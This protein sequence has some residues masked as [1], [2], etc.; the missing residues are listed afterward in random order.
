[1]PTTVSLHPLPG[2]TAA[3][4]SLL[5]GYYGLEE[6]SVR[7][8]VRIS[9]QP[10]FRS[11][12]RPLR[13]KS[14][15]V[16]LSGKAICMFADMR[17]AIDLTK[18][19]H[20]LLHQ[21]VS[22]LAE[23]ESVP[24]GTVIE[25]PFDIP[26]PPDPDPNTLPPPP[27]GTNASPHL[28][29]PSMCFFG[30]NINSYQGRV[31]YEVVAT[32]TEVAS[33]ALGFI[34]LSPTVHSATTSLNPF[35][36]YDPRLLPTLL[37]P[38]IR[39]WRS[40]PGA[41]PVEYDIEVGAMAMGP[42]DTLRFAYRIVVASDS[43]RKGVRVKK[44]SL[45]LREHHVVG[46]QT[47][48]GRAENSEDPIERS[49]A[50]VKGMVELLRWEQAEESP[51]TSNST[52]ELSTMRSPDRR[53]HMGLS[54]GGK[55]PLPRPGFI[56]R[57]GDGLYAES[58]T[59]LKIPDV[60]S[61]AP[62][63]AKIT[64][65]P[66]VPPDGESL[67]AHVEVRHSLQVTIEF[68]GADKLVM[69]S[70]CV[71]SSVGREDCGKLLDHD[72]EIAP[73]L[74]Y[75]KIVGGADVWVPEYTEEDEL[76]E[77]VKSLSEE[78]LE[79]IRAVLAAEAEPA[80]SRAPPISAKANIPDDRAAEAPTAPSDD[81]NSIS[82]SDIVASSSETEASP[83]VSDSNHTFTD[84]E[85]EPIEITFDPEPNCGERDPLGPTRPA[86]LTSELREASVPLFARE[87]ASPEERASPTSA[88]S[89][90]IPSPASSLSS[91]YHS[92]LSHVSAPS[93]DT[94]LSSHTAVSDA[95]SSPALSAMPS[96]PGVADDL[97]LLK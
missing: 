56:C 41:I 72:P 10:G 44:I 71:L 4:Q 11:G 28:L 58:E 48:H 57:G 51:E 34:P 18:R 70:G 62:T 19:E 1:M 32:L 14:L 47:C 8:V 89:S 29:P 92:Y 40:A 21:T 36:V 76:A 81:D 65:P 15:A 7:G 66:P 63:T 2:A 55:S 37:H 84:E 79:A 95:P 88:S 16:T 39:R 87:S 52:F 75:D 49:G 6:C 35:C 90:P 93:S 46:E 54:A 24:L 3:S 86:S 25:I 85:S 30:S 43:A 50:K 9:H 59:S 22:L 13:I 80:S 64:Q 77:A 94:P 31:V 5:Q 68:I 27:P 33:T 69:E 67:P 38:D 17:E 74:D 42:G 78:A 82:A 97:I 26:L 60:G 20:I 53:V 23:P 96:K 91:S 45:A 61:F 73:A 12:S 83:D